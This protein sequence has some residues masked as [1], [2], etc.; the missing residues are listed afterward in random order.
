MSAF[1]SR[2]L[3]PTSVWFA[4]FVFR[5]IEKSPRAV[6][7]RFPTDQVAGIEVDKVKEAET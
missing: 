4:T 2:M 3:L 5:P 1:A 7:D 6:R